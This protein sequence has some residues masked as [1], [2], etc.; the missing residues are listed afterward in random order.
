MF[1]HF[2]IHQDLVLSP[3]KNQL[4]LLKMKLSAMTTTMPLRIPRCNNLK[5]S[6]FK[7][8]IMVWKLN[9]FTGNIQITFLNESLYFGIASVVTSS[10][11]T[12]FD[13]CFNFSNRT[14]FCLVT[15]YSICLNYSYLLQRM[16]L[17]KITTLLTLMEITQMTKIRIQVMN[18]LMVNI[19]LIEL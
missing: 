13:T 19:L 9:I 5:W 7:I 14:K 2:I 10:D 15:H 4:P 8:Q 3:D 18:G 12:N 11:F 1:V 16:F 6:K 17:W